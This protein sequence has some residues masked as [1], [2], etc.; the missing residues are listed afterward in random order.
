[1]TG[2]EQEN[3]VSLGYQKLKT[4]NFAGVDAGKVIEPDFTKALDV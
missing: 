4:A 1:M 2:I 3:I